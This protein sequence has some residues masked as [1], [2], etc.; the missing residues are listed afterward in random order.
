MR[1]QLFGYFK[2]AKKLTK[3]ALKLESPLNTEIDLEEGSLKGYNQ[4]TVRKLS[5]MKS[6][7][8]DGDE[9]KKILERGEDPMIYEFYGYEPVAE[10]GRLSFG[11]T[12]INPGKIG[13]EYYMTKGHFHT[14]R[15]TAEIYIGLKGRGFLLMQNKFGDVTLIEMERG[16]VA[17][18]PPFW[19][20]RTINV[21]DEKFV[22]MFIFPADAGHDYATIEERGFNKIVVEKEGKPII[23]NRS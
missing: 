13:D 16:T 3:T 22:F 21:G 8:Y 23:A 14:K 17:F 1:T 12:V 20:H 4:K 2:H 9:V 7:F 18:V 10:N 11:V 15:E 5:D 6:F 19:A